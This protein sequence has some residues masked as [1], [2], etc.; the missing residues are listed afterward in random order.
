MMVHRWFMAA[1][2]TLLALMGPQPQTEAVPR[3]ATA[4]PTAAK[5]KPGVID[6]RA[7]AA[8]HQM[9][10]Y[11]TGLKTLRVRVSTVEEMVTTEGQKIQQVKDSVVTM[12]RPNRLRVER[13]SPAGHAT[14]NYDGKE[15]AIASRERKIYA[16]AP[17]PPTLTAAIDTARDRLNIDA[18]AADLLVPDS[19]DA[20]TD[21]LITGRYIGLEPIDGVMA[22]HL[23]ATKDVVDWQIWIKDGPQPLPLRFV[24]TTKDLPSRPQFTATFSN[25]EPDAT[26]LDQAFSFTPPPGSRKVK[27]TASAQRKPQG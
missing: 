11:L 13:V 26:V 20:L 22:H 19:Y 14:F 9:S 5:R 27:F 1:V 6:A 17:A 23:A 3:A 21:G 4:K 16:T 18:P 10:D 25:W 24:I 2:V 7:A 15:F 8:L 12:R